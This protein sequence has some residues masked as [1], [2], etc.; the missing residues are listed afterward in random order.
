MTAYAVIDTT[1]SEHVGVFNSK[2]IASARLAFKAH[3]TCAA[4]HQA[5]PLDEVFKRY[6]IKEIEIT[7]RRILK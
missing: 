2:S 3:I 5:Q 6:T 1:T 4:Q 7:D